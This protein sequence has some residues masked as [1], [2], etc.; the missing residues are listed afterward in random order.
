M[1]ADKAGSALRTSR[2]TCILTGVTAILLATIGLFLSFFGT[3][4]L[5]LGG[6]PYYLVAAVLI[7]AS[8]WFV[9]TGNVWGDRFYALFLA[10]TIVFT[11]VEAGLAPW[12]VMPRVVGPAVI[13]LLFFLPGVAGQRVAGVLPKGLSGLLSILML[14]ILLAVSLGKAMGSDPRLAYEALAGTMP[15]SSEWTSYGGGPGA[16]RHSPLAAISAGNVAGLKLAWT[17]HSGDLGRSAASLAI[18]PL[19]L[20]DLV[21]SCTP[22][23]QVIAIDAASG[24]ERWRFDP[25]VKPAA[26]ATHTCRSLAS[27]QL[28][29]SR[30][31]M[32]E[33]AAVTQAEA[34]SRR[35]F[36]ATLDSRLIAIDA[37][38]GARC[39]GFG[40][41]GAV[42]LREGIPQFSPTLSYQ[43]SGPAVVGDLVVIGGLVL[44]NQSTNAPSGVIR[45]YDA[46]TGRLRWAWDMGVPDRMG[47]PGA[48]QLY[49][50]ST[51]NAWAP[52][53]GDAE[54]GLIYV[55]LGNPS[56]DFFGTGRRDFDEKYGSSIVALSVADGRPR[57]SFQ[58]VHHDLWDYDVPMQALLADL[59]IGGAIRHALIQGT[60]Q[61]DLYV[62]DRQTG[63]PIIPVGERPAPQGGLP[64]ERHSPTQPYS[65][66]S[67]TPPR[68]READMWGL[69]PLD[70]LI[71][72]VMFRKAR[73]QGKFT[74]PGRDT[75]LIYPGL[76]GMMSWGGLSFDPERRQL[77]ANITLIPWL[78]QLERKEGVGAA[79]TRERSKTAPAGLEM[80]GT[81]YRWIQKPFLSP[82]GIPCNAPPWGKLVG[83]DVARQKINWSTPL[84]TG[85]DFGPLGLHA[86]IPLRIGTPNVGGPMTTGGGLVFIGAAMD[87]YLRAFDLRN[88]S[89]LWRARLPAG[90]QATP[91]TYAQGS[92]QYVVVSSGGH[93]LLGTTPGD[94]TVAF[95]IP[96]N[97]ND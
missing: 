24:K 77:V 80:R 43:T 89:E 1:S 50:A 44:D 48:G 75:S 22:S 17:H 52:M 69:T 26:Y 66:L 45:G 78:G 12:L 59:N 73:Y 83:V 85:R 38:S 74:P 62:L 92:R 37:Y 82:L 5:M 21:Y 79:A 65:A 58:F 96:A 61:G 30:G 20:G 90:A 33:G 53:T 57:W 56:P 40:T 51:P 95:T 36:V 39:R 31:A 41:A 8:A 7:L 35:I 67:L 49:T 70:Q 14:I 11:L 3:E 32:P 23:N 18:T 86:G 72:R 25:K 16:Q 15:V 93:G 97:D 2:A 46:M 71:C 64:E 84:G 42:D 47:A 55:P 81:P 54:L 91:I 19:K 34:C 87:N 94:A 27:Y 9:F 68:L 60:K 10:I 29:A 4:L 88:G 28:P 6:H 76:T 63:R 13:G